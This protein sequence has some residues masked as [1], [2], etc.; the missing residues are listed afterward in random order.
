MAKRIFAAV[1]MI[2]LFLSF[3]LPLAQAA[4]DGVHKEQIIVDSLGYHRIEDVLLDKDGTVFVPVEWFTRYGLMECREE[5]SRYVFYNV[6]EEADKKFAK[7]I[8]IDKSIFEA[9]CVCYTSETEYVT[10][11]RHQFTKHLTDGNSLYLPLAEMLPLFNA[12]LEISADGILHIYPNPV[13]IFSALYGIDMDALAF[14]A[15]RDMVGSGFIEATGIIFDSV[16]D[17]R[18]DRLDG[19]YNTGEYKDYCELFKAYL[20]DDEVFLA[21]FDGAKSPAELIIEQKKNALKIVEDT[22]SDGEAFPSM[23]EYL[24][25][26]EQ[27]P[28]FHKFGEFYSDL[29]D[30]AE[31]VFK[32]A[33][34]YNSYVNQID[35]H[36]EMLEAVYSPQF[37]GSANPAYKAAVSTLSLYGTDS[38]A[39]TKQLIFS[40]IRDIIIDEFGDLAVSEFALNPYTIS[41]DIVKLIR[42]EA[43]EIIGDAAQLGYM[44]D[45]VH[46]SCTIFDKRAESIRFDTEYLNDLRLTAMLA[47]VASRH[48]YKT[49]WDDHSKVDS[50]NPV[51]T[52]LYLAAESVP[53]EAADNYPVR[54]AKLL[55]TMYL[56]DIDGVDSGIVNPTTTTNKDIR[57]ALTEWF[58]QNWF[59]EHPDL[60][61]QWTLA[62][63]M[64][65]THD[66]YDDLVVR[67]MTPSYNMPSES[68]DYLLEV[69]TAPDKNVRKIYER[70]DSD[71]V[72]ST[73]VLYIRPVSEGYNL[74]C[75]GGALWQGSG[76]EHTYE[77]Y[78]TQH[79][80]EQL[81]NSCE[82]SGDPVSDAQWENYFSERSPMMSGSIPF[83]LDSAR[84]GLLDSVLHYIHIPG[85]DL[86][87]LTPASPA[88]STP[89]PAPMP[90]A[91]P[92]PAPVTTPQATQQPEYYYILPY[93]DSMYY[94]EA[95][96]QGMSW[97]DCSLARNEIFARRGRLFVNAE[98]DE[99]FRAQAWYSGYIL[100]ADFDP[101]VFNEYE[102]ANIK[103]ISD[104]ETALWGGSYFQQ[105]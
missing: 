56:L 23:V 42:P 80:Q 57:I 98:I 45:V 73:H 18:W 30:T 1:I 64:D 97:R 105:E 89:E 70:L 104:Y 55:E 24:F 33:D 25:E 15:S 93:S 86:D 4:N 96:L 43:T 84:E 68:S 100:P 52:N 36:L 47:L 26:S 13:S 19:L 39:Q 40:A 76:D 99:Y 46:N 102:L 6:G 20:T 78:I 60:N 88:P 75:S 7:R 91:E 37:F 95:D 69:Y 92:T 94:T 90:T 17:R 27:Y 51:L 63:L 59:A 65:V 12:K 67:S 54:V 44:D 101:G 74:V 31:G 79:G 85:G 11:L 61:P 16:L 5:A 66:G 35:D 83:D 9:S 28:E 87:T 103:L 82:V 2:A 21:A 8:N 32:F 71:W 29:A 41:F 62:L 49:F 72:H 34:Y 10:Y 3:S 53:C 22:T 48:A 38:T 77:F 81:V 50:I 14:N 58:G